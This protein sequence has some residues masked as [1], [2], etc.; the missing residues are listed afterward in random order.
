M[1]SHGR[2]WLGMAGNGKLNGRDSRLWATAGK[3]NLNEGDSEPW[4]MAGN[5]NLNVAASHGREW[6]P[7]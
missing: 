6:Q 1:A 3:D 7:Q 4:S 2:E 5:G